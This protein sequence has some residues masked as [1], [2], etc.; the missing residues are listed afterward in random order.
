MTKTANTRK[1]R[2]LAFPLWLER[3]TES[4]FAQHPEATEAEFRVHVWQLVENNP[5]LAKQMCEDLFTEMVSELHRRE[6]H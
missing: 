3:E 5:E 2:K 6:A 1:S 4:Y